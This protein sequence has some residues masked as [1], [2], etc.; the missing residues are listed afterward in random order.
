M[1]STPDLP[2]L[3]A[4]ATPNYA[5]AF[6]ESQ[7]PFAKEQST[8]WSAAHLARISASPDSERGW[9]ERVVKWQKTIPD[10]CLL[11]RTF[12]D[13]PDAIF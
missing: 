7:Q 3:R 13:A 12:K 6:K 8:F 5:V 9:T 10:E 4:H 1:A 11:T 2:S